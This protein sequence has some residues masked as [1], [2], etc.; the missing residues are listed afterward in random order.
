M[1]VDNPYA[2]IGLIKLRLNQLV[3]DPPPKIVASGSV[4]SVIDDIM[5]HCPGLFILPGPSPVAGSASGSVSI[6]QRIQIT[7][8]IQAQSDPEAVLTTD[9]QAGEF[10]GQIVR[11]LHDWEPSTGRIK[12]QFTGFAEPFFYHG[13]YSEYPLLFEVRTVLNSRGVNENGG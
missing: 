4:L 8:G 12:M 3:I 11:A 13:G 10:A 9:E 5:P 2:L 6:D 1:A 7:I